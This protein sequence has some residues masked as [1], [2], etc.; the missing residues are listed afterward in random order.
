VT[1]TSAQPAAV[2]VAVVLALVTAAVAVV[3]HD[4]FADMGGRLSF[5]CAVVDDAGDGLVTPPSTRAVSHGPTPRASWAA[6]ARSPS[7]PRSRTP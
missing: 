3:R 6:G 5:S 7:A 4:A 2:V 1:L